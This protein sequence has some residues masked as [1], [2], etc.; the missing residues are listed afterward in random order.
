[1][2]TIEKKHG[3]IQVKETDWQHLFVIAENWQSDLN[4][5]TDE[6][7]FLKGLFSTYILHLLE[8]KNN[9]VKLVDRLNKLDREIQRI[10]RVTS[11]HIRHLADHFSSPFVLSDPAYVEE[12]V[13]LEK[14]VQDLM[15]EFRNLK[16][17]LYQEMEA[18]LKDEKRKRLIS[19]I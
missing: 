8:R 9:A 15:K 16:K 3:N 10:K 13:H 6:I 18:V 12:H 14:N 2:E 19:R 5:F 4:F 1:M 17:E 7:K 11:S